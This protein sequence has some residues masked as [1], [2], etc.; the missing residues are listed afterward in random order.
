MRRR[1][2]MRR[3]SKARGKN[4]GRFDESRCSLNAGKIKTG[5]INVGKLSKTEGTNR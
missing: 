5:K 4:T 3:K 1:V 2:K